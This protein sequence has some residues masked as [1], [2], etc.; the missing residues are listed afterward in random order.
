L[1]P[2][3]IEDYLVSELV[4]DS[5]E[6]VRKY[7]EKLDRKQIISLF[8]SFLDKQGEGEI[9]IPIS[10]L[11]NRKVSGLESIVKFL[12]E[13][14]KLSNSNVAKLLGRSQQ[15]CWTT[16]KNAA[17]KMKERFTFSMS[18]IDI[19]AKVFR[20]RFSVLEAIVMFLVTNGRSFHEIAV[21]LAR[22]DRT[23]WTTYQRAMRK[24]GK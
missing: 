2:Q 4:K 19:P 1:A 24:H 18:D 16:Y 9:R 15:V 8:D 20:S 14:V 13:E 21:A 7:L 12:R 22:D 23:I 11:K 10:V 6:I 3:N 5:S 17:R